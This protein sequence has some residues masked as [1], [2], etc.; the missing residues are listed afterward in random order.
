MR[1]ERPYTFGFWMMVVIV[2]FRVFLLVAITIA[3][4]RNKASGLSFTFNLVMFVMVIV[5]LAETM[6]Y[7]NRRYKIPN[8][9]W[10]HIHIWSTFLAMVVIPIVTYFLMSILMRSY[11][12][13]LPPETE[14]Y[15]G[16]SYHDVVARYTTIQRYLFWGL[17]AVGHIFF[18]V[19]I[20]KS[21]QLKDE[22][23]DESTGLLDEFID[24][25]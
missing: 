18:I 9:A 5:L 11:Y 14:Y 7:W 20:V 25:R 21:F 19:T 23:P 17:L 8:K 22:E 2:V 12:Q 1:R 3:L 15:N 24:R 16:N 4:Q 10:V 6:F 13:Q